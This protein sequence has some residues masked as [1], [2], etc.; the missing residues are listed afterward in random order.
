MQ[1]IALLNGMAK[2]ITVSAKW[3]LLSSI[4]FVGS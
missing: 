1:L 3:T 2:M 4:T